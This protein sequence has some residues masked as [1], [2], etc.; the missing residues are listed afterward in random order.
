MPADV[1]DFVTGGSGA[2]STL[3]ANRAALDRLYLVPRALVDVSTTDTSTCLVG[4]PASMP[5][6]IA[7]MAYQRLVHPDGEVAAARAAKAAGVPFVISTLSSCPIED[8]ASVGAVTWFQLYWLRDRA[9]VE[10]LVR[11]AEEAGCSALVLTVDVP[12]LGRRLRDARRGFVLPAHV[13]AANLPDGAVLAGARQSG[14][15]VAAHT[16]AVVDPSLSWRD[17]EWLCERTRLPVVLKGVLDPDDAGRAAD[18]AAAVVVSN[19]GG[20]QLDG[21]VPSIV[22]LPA[23]REAVAGRCEVLMD[24]G[25]RSGVDVLKAVARGADGVL[26]GR[27]VLHGLAASGEAG[28]STVLSLLREELGDAL[29]LAG[30]ADLSTARRLRVT[31]RPD[32]DEGGSGC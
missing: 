12:R 24:S 29:A 32:H 11:R 4:T 9:L 21:A 19:H 25:V 22:A 6:A 7:P 1:R 14:S 16:S 5:M 31:V 18:L 3:R 26:V 8:I 2:E 13:R 15:A 28:V 30:C 27:P 23:V 10:D 20:R 17:V